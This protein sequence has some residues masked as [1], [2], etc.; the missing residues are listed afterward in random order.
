MVKME[1]KQPQGMCTALEP[2]RLL[3]WKP[4]KVMLCQAHIDDQGGIQISTN[5]VQ[6]STGGV[7]ISTIAVQISM[8]GSLR[9]PTLC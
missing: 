9:D 6:T 3:K 7:Q 1:P 5:N 2:S 4:A 8:G